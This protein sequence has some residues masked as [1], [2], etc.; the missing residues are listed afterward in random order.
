MTDAMTR[1]NAALSGR[2][3]I[4]RQLGEGGMA[5]VYLAQDLKHDRRV[6]LKVLKP[7]LAAVLGAERF[8]A[9]IKTTANLQHPHI[10]PL[11]DSGQADGLLFYVMPY[12]EGET[13]RDRLDREHQ[14]PVEEAVRIATHVAQALDYAHRH[15]VIHRDIKPANILLHDGQP[16]VSD[17]GIALAVTSGG[18]GRLTE[19]G[20]SLGTPHYMSPEQATGDQ[21]VGPATDVYALGCVLYEMLAGEPPYTGSTPQAI[22]GKIIQAEPVSATKARR[23]VPVN[24]DAAIR[25]ALEKV[26]ADRFAGAADFAR[27]LADAGFRHG[28]AAGLPAAAGTGAPTWLAIGL[29]GT[30]TLLGFVAVWALLR[31]AELAP[32]ARFTVSPPE[33]TTYPFGRARENVIAL[34]PD[35]EWLAF[36]TADGALHRRR[37][38]RLEAEPVPDGENATV[39]FF[40]PDSRWLGF[41]SNGQLRKVPMSGG[42]PVPITEVVEGTF[43]ASWGDGDVI[44]FDSWNGQNGSLYTV[45][46]DGG[47]PTLVPGT[48]EGRFERPWMLPGGEAALVTLRAN[49]GS[50]ASNRVAAIDLRTGTVDTLGFGTRAAYASGYLLTVGEDG[51]LLAQ[52]FDPAKRQAIGPSVAILDRVRQGDF[53]PSGSGGL[54]YLSGASSGDALVITGATGTEQVPLPDRGQPSEPAFSP[55][56][57]RIAM[58]IQGLGEAE[59]IW[60][61]DRDQGTLDRLTTVGE[62]NMRPSWT[63]DGRRVAFMSHRGDRVGIYWQP[64]DGSGPAEPML[65]GDDGGAPRAWSPD[66]R[67]LAFD[68]PGDIGLLTLGDS[69]ARWV[70]ATEFVEIH[71]DVSPDGRWLAYASNRTGAFEVYVR[72]LSGEGRRFQVSNGGGDSPRWAPEGSVL[73]YAT[74][75]DSGSTSLVAATLSLDGPSGVI[76]RQARLEVDHASSDR[77][78]APMSYDVSPDGEEF[79]HVRGGAADRSL[80]WVLNWPQILREMTGGP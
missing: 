68:G 34:S 58:R 1:L 67:T 11:H 29:A 37:L 48:E 15:G 54:A 79:V 12:V 56:G 57:R 27:A 78:L 59:D 22:L 28:V 18:A 45:A 32:L 66:G 50:E 62:L 24:V 52:P 26:P 60:I 42:P 17:F 49:P 40:S 44:V 4:E 63:P 23:T 33:N 20:L 47:V 2:Y 69:V 61:L 3:R 80:V 73:Y 35:G 53:W 10:L 41:A 6:A 14:L 16:V 77:G 75:G 30:T 7:E 19:T 71:P 36:V 38:G 72:P 76:A 31:P 74:T 8:L 64:S 70:E 13:L 43:G 51:N 46:A 21:N 5:T 9:E 25:R 65:D 39:P 55:D